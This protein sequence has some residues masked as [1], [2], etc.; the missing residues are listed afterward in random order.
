M[1]EYQNMNKR[2][3]VKR[4]LS[5]KYLMISKNNLYQIR[6]E[7]F[8]LGW[9][10]ALQKGEGAGQDRPYLVNF[11]VHMDGGI[12]NLGFRVGLIVVAGR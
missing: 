9:V 8:E 4:K 3:G 7:N 2:Q 11:S 10:W 6:K 1:F 12:A 5:P